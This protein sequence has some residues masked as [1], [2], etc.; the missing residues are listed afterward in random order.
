MKPELVIFDF[1]NTLAFAADYDP[2]KFFARLGDFSINIKGKD[3]A[4]SFSRSFSK[5]MCFAKDWNDFSVQLL[6]EFGSNQGAEDI[7]R[8]ADFLQGNVTY[9]LYDDIKEALDLPYKKTILTDSAKFLVESADLRGFEKI[10]TPAETGSLK[11][12]P[13]VFLKTLEGF[14]VSPDEAVMVGDDPERDIAPAKKLGITTILI[15]R[16]NKFPDSPGL[17]IVS[18]A[19]LQETIEGL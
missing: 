9:K 16:K 5:M 2:Q 12:D 7:G 4:E 10:F 18:M 19:E 17:R 13:K 14:G 6:K 15:D 3:E 1:W 11:P 8:F